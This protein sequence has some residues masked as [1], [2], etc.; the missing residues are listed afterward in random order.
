MI[1][2]YEEIYTE[3]SVEK[4]KKLMSTVDWN[5]ITQTLNTHIIFSL[6]NF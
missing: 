6:M 2:L 3:S 1:T 4:F 5:L